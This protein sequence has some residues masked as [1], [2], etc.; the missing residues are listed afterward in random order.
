MPTC[1]ST[2]WQPSL[3]PTTIATFSSS[4]KI[5]QKPDKIPNFTPKL[6]SLFWGLPRW[7]ELDKKYPF[8]PA[9]QFHRN[10]QDLSCSARE[11]EIGNFSPLTW[12]GALFH[13]GIFASCH[14]VCWKKD[15]FVSF[16]FKSGCTGSLLCVR[17]IIWNLILIVWW[18]AV[19]ATPTLEL[20]LKLMK[21][22][23]KRKLVDRPSCKKCLSVVQ[24]V[25]VFLVA[26]RFCA[27]RFSPHLESCQFL[28]APMLMPMP[29]H[30]LM[31]TQTRKTMHLNF[32]WGWFLVPTLS[33]K[34]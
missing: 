25:T 31:Q 5:H 21:N 9:L 10:W 12:R 1:Q 20:K 29:S 2:S 30:F 11:K 26:S 6:S 22:V 33:P 3:S 16:Q 18:L 32:T 7:T 23:E 34:K 14:L 13:L 15:N 28:C 19:L 27:S 17:L 24:D 4:A 8:Q